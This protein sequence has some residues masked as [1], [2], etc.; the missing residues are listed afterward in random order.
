MNL[1]IKKGLLWRTGKAAGCSSTQ[2]RQTRAELFGIGFAMGRAGS[3]IRSQLMG[4]QQQQARIGASVL[5]FVG[6]GVG[7]GWA[8]L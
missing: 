8:S 1:K 4:K 5:G 7:M 6:V 2:S 3:E